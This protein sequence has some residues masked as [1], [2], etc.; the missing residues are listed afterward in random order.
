MGD[1]VALVLVGVI[2]TQKIACP[3]LVSLKLVGA[4][5]KALKSQSL[6]MVFALATI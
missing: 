3:N 5:L 4:I 6:K 1:M 2:V